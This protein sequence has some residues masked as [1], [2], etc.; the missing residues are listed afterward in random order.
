MILRLL[1]K[2]FFENQKEKLLIIRIV[3]GGIKMYKKRS[4][5]RSFVIK[6]GLVVKVQK[7]GKVIEWPVGIVRKQ[8]LMQRI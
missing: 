1:Q 8:F 6:N 2:M 5:I 7:S 3:G 4:R